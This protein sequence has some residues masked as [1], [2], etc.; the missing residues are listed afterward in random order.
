M[1]CRLLFLLCVMV[2]TVVTVVVWWRCVVVGGP[3]GSWHS[4][5]NDITDGLAGTYGIPC[6]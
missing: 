5:Y 2:A 6:C 3:A 1:V 4:P